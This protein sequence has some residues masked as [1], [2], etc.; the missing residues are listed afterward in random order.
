MSWDKETRHEY[1]WPT[2]ND[3]HSP[4]QEGGWTIKAPPRPNWE[5]CLGGDWHACTFQLYYR[6]PPNWFH[7]LM[8]RW[9]LGIHWRKIDG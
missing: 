4:K 9:L 7:R 1:V 3:L 6:T 5:W 2:V 8:Q